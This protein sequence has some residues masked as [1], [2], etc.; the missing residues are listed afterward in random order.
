MALVAENFGK[1]SASRSAIRSSTVLIDLVEER[2]DVV[3]TDGLTLTGGGVDNVVPADDGALGLPAAAIA[4]CTDERLL[5][6][7][8]I[9]TLSID[10][11]H[12]RNRRET[13]QFKI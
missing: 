5:L 8:G 4:L 1:L 2:D 6:V 11:R 10:L 7:L 9:V 13:K 12:K 3:I